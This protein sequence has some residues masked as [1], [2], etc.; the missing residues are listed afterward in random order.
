MVVLG[1]DVHKDSHTVVAVDEA[2]R[3]L[4]GWSSGTRTRDCE[5]LIARAREAFPEGGV[6]AVE[7]C[8]HVSGR[9]ERALLDAGE[10]C[11][12]VPPKLMAGAAARGPHARQVRPD[13]RAGGRPGRAGESG[14][15]GR[16]AHAMPRG[17]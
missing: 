16:R 5:A 2:G 6:W 17:R 14:T 10:R 8:R 3:E 7:D 4:V 11:E 12:R 15:A 13:R 1:V 9:L